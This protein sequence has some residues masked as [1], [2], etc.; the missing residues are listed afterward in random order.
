VT[1]T[2][3]Q[4]ARESFRTCGTCKALN[5][6]DVTECRA[7]G[8]RLDGDYDISFSLILTAETC[9]SCGRVS[10]ATPCI[11]CG[12]DVPRVERTGGLALSRRKAFAKLLSRLE[13]LQL[14][15]DELPE[16]HVT[17]A[18]DQYGAAIADSGV[19]KRAR[20][21]M[22][23]LH[24]IDELGLNE[25]RTIGTTAR[26]GLE[27]LVVALEEI[28]EETKQVAWFRAPSD[29]VARARTALIATGR[30]VNELVLTLLQVLSALSVEDVVPLQARFQELLANYPF[31]AEFSAALAALR[32]LPSSDVDERV[33]L[34]LGVEVFVTDGLGLLDPGRVLTAFAGD[35]DPFTPLG[36]SCARYL[37]HLSTI[38]SESV[39]V[40]SAALAFGALGLIVLD[41]P[42]PA[43]RLAR[44]VVELLREARAKD[45][46]AMESLLERTIGEGPR[47][48]AAAKR[49]HDDLSYLS[50]GLAR[51]EDEIVA[52]LVATYKRLAESSF[53]N[54]VWLIADAQQIAAGRKRLTTDRAPMLGE[55]EQR[56]ASRGDPLSKGLLRA[57]D[58]LLRNAEA[59]ENFRFDASRGEI[60]VDS[61][62]M[63]LERFG[64]KVERLV[65]ASV[66]LDAAFTC[67]AYEN[68]KLARVPEWLA[69]G[70]APFAAEFL[71]RGFLG[72]YAIE[73]HELQ[74]GD[75]LTLV[76]EWD[77]PDR[78]RA[79]TPLCAIA[80]L[81]PEA[82]RL[83]VQLKNTEK[84]LVA[85]ER[86]AFDTFARAP[87]SVKDLALLAS[88]YSAG[89]EA[90]REP[91]AM[92]EEVLALCIALVAAT[93]VPRLKI[94]LGIG[95]PA[96]LVLLEE[97]LTYVVCLVRERAGKLPPKTANVLTSLGEAKVASMFARRGNPGAIQRMTSALAR[98]ASWADAHGY[99][100]P[101]I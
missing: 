1:L 50:A 33:S 82:R 70:E 13:H 29:E 2:D 45:P 74:L 62:R 71:T 99:R 100:W 41:R 6:D 88:L 56:L 16:P 85:V 27:R 60:V 17:V 40:E 48:F 37:S 81:F 44:Q 97:R 11:H 22:G 72:A 18:P 79:L 36:R 49:I 63:T 19:L 65:S 83:V 61:K 4:E 47:I 23:S 75:D 54:Y 31:Q 89:V 87:E 90:G 86:T 91:D 14:S 5:A 43:H 80:Q 101:P 3:A 52:R 42:L 46:M 8:E 32:E 20:I 26:M 10:P 25:E 59:H 55:L 28:Y 24:R 67:Q 94:A 34:A 58:R 68:G 39:E 35:D 95:N 69:S 64:R 92:V 21:V 84:P 12:A 96:P 78:V 93:D 77:F 66:G 15:Y 76:V 57:M 53:R 73:L 98:A 30:Y 51:D 38:E 9:D 7:C